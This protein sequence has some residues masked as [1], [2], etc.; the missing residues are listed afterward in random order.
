MNPANLWLNVHLAKH[1]RAMPRSTHR[2]P[3]PNSPTA[4]RPPAK[5]VKLTS[6]LALRLAGRRWFPLWAVV[7]HRGR[8]SGKDYSIPVAVIVT[9]NSFI[10]GLP[11]GPKTN[12]AQNVLAAG[13]CAIRWKAQDYQVTNPGWSGSDRAVAAAN[14]LEGKILRRTG[15]EGLPRGPA[16]TNPL[17][18]PDRWRQVLLRLPLGP[19]QMIPASYLDVTS[20][21]NVASS[22]VNLLGHKIIAS[23]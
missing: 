1:R 10:I 11:W 18:R 7:R 23:A 22:L 12:W 14:R 2:T 6:P 15:D 17:D 3:G 16:L 9:P 4:A 13:G 8:K 20:R 5:L 19:W 21:S